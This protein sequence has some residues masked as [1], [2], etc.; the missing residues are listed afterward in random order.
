MERMELSGKYLMDIPQVDEQH[1]RLVELLNDLN[2]VI[3]EKRDEDEVSRI[4]DEFIA[5]THYHFNDEETLMKEK[6]YPNLESHS[7]IH[8][9][10][11]NQVEKTIIQYSGTKFLRFKFFQIGMDLLMNHIEKEDYKFSQFLKNESL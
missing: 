9:G 3:E 10:F 2:E 8:R 6:E 1:Q 11:V 7:A 4:V 5:Y